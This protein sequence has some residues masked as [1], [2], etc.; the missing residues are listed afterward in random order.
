MPHGP[1]LFS[2]WPLFWVEASPLLLPPFAP[3]MDECVVVGSN[4]FWAK[5]FFAEWDIG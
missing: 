2:E 5:L 3:F 4:C 1:P